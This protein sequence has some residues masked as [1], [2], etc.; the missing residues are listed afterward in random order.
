MR[1]IRLLHKALDVEYCS[2]AIRFLHAAQLFTPAK[3]C[4]FQYRSFSAGV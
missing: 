3:G 1:L 2:K 4:Q